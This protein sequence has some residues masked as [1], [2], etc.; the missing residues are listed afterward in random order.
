MVSRE[1]AELRARHAA[2]SNSFAPVFRGS[3]EQGG[4]GTV[5]R[6]RFVVH[7][8]A[9]RFMYLAIGFLIVWIA[10]VVALLLAVT[11]LATVLPG[12]ASQVWSGL[13]GGLEAVAGA[14]GMLAASIGLVFA[15]KAIGV[16]DV[17]VI[18]KFLASRIGAAAQQGAAADRQG[19]GPD[20]PL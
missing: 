13:R 8:F 5:L 11:A 14:T 6:G 3:F 17:A 1:R 2:F 18:S 19:P 15:G 4:S 12:D 9:K 10:A 20:Q 7:P 16:R